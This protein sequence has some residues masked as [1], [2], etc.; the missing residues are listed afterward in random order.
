MDEVA[1]TRALVLL[2]GPTTY[3]FS[4]VVSVVIAGIALGSA[5]SSR[6][7][8]RSQRPVSLLAIVQILAALS[9][10]SVIQ[11]I[12]LLPVPVG[13]LI[14]ANADHMSWLLLV[15]FLWIFLLLIIPSFLFGAAFP[16]A[17]RLLYQ[18]VQETGKAT[19]RIYAWNTVGAV[20]GSLL[21]GF[22]FLPWIGMESTLYMAAIVHVV[23]G[24]LLLIAGLRATLRWA[25]PVAALGAS[26]LG[27]SVLPHWDR[28][29]LSGGTYKYTAY[30]GE[31]EVLDFLRRGDLLPLQASIHSERR[32]SQTGPPMPNDIPTIIPFSSFAPLA[33][34]TPTLD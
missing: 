26:V 32:S 2:I 21:A 29:L 11:I 1:W 27:P 34:C 16:L 10:I 12:G 6:W 3:G 5:V 18:S 20:A 17:A 25:L 8:A 19:G 15:E 23:A 13:Q 24:A 28:E 30:L 7:A 9:T 33:S 31:G 4:F 14:R 22:L